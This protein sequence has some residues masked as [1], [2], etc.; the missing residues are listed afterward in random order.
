MLSG[1][2]IPLNVN[3]RRINLQQVVILAR[4]WRLLIVKGAEMKVKTSYA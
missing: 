1:I 2:V 3:A 4:Q